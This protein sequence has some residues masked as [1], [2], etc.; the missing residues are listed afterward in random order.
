MTN[1]K[2]NLKVIKTIC[3]VANEGPWLLIYVTS[4][5]NNSGGVTFNCHTRLLLKTRMQ[6]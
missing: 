5:G 3:S 2:Y 4:I 1:M 6:T